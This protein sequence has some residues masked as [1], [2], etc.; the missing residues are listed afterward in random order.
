MSI[1]EPVLGLVHFDGEMYNIIKLFDEDNEE[2]TDP[3][4]AC[5][6]LIQRPKDARPEGT[7]QRYKAWDIPLGSLEVLSPS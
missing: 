3:A 6:L 4:L 1:N 2:T 7:E 5:K